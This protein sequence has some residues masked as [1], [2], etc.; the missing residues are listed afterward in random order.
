MTG[1]E[2]DEKLWGGGDPLLGDI[3][4]LAARLDEGEEAAAALPHRRKYLLL[5]IGFL[6]RYLELHLELVDEVERELGPGRR[7]VRKRRTEPSLPGT[8]GPA[9]PPQVGTMPGPRAAAPRGWA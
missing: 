4:D 5:V 2:L 8:R 1:E 6:R 9:E 7:S 3:A